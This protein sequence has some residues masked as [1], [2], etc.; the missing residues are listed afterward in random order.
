MELNAFLNQLIID[1]E[2]VCDDIEF[3]FGNNTV[4]EEKVRQIKRTV[5]DFQNEI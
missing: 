1:L 5:E 2:D 4:P 3:D